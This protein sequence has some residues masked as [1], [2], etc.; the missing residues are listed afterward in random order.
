MKKKNHFFSRIHVEDIA[1]ILRLSLKKFVPGQIFN[2]SDNYPCSNEELV[3]Y[4]A[5]LIKIDMPKKIKTSD[6]KNE[7]LK[8][9]YKDSKKVNNK[10]MKNF[11]KYKLKYPSFKEGLD[12]IKN[13]IV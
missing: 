5:N 10:K 4:A 3:S 2:I 7:N 8:S 1:E 11:F 13:H 12:V 6:I 9:F